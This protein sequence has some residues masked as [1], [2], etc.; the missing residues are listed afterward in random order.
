MFVLSDVMKDQ[1]KKRLLSTNLA[2]AVQARSK[3]DLA[4]QHLIA[5]RHDCVHELKI[6]AR[7][8][9]RLVREELT[10]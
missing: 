5:V 8:F 10:R 3:I 6:S 9:N 2:K 4:R 7:E 1:E